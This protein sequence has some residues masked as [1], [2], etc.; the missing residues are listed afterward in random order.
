MNPHL[1]VLIP[2]A[3]LGAALAAAFFPPV[4]SRLAAWGGLGLGLFFT[5]LSFSHAGEGPWHY[6][7]GGWPPPWGIELAVAPFTGLL[8]CLFL[9]LS[10]ACCFYGVV[11]GAPAP[12]AIRNERVFYPFLLFFTAALLLLLL[13]K[14]AFTL[15]LGLESALLAAAHLADANGQNRLAAF[16]LFLYGS[17]GASV[18]LFGILLLYATTG[19]L[20]LDDLLAQLF[21]S[22]NDPVALTAGMFAALGLGLP[23]LFPAPLFF[24][25]LLNQAPAFVMGLLAAA[26][27]RGAA[28]LLFVFLFFVLNV[29]GLAP[30][31]ALT[32]LE[33]LAA[34]LFLAGFVGASRQKDFQQAVAYLGVAQLGFL[35][36]GFLL[37]GKSALTGTLM[38]FLSQTLVVAGLFFIAGNL[39]TQPGPQLISRMAGLARHRPLTGLALVVFTASIVG[40][41]PTGGFFGK[42][43]LIQGALEKRDWAALALLGLAIA[44]NFFTFAKLTAF[45]YENRGPSLSHG[46][47]SLGLKAPIL[48]LAAGVLLLGLFHQGVIHNFIEPALPKAF[49][50]LPVPNVPFLGHEVE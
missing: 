42:F 2:L 35:F 23:L 26:L 3:L 49:Q 19:T 22:K 7:L 48:L 17:A 9:A 16:H 21:I 39:K 37:G 1:P 50:N 30:P 25:R 5:I 27:P 44:F 11:E 18:F 13:A 10:L 33:Y 41:P 46:P 28:Y 12:P 38:E 24:A 15:Y 45:L 47:A 4:L 40:V 29:P 20:H 6:N 8:A 14:D 32:V 34:A 31:A 43:Y 36:L